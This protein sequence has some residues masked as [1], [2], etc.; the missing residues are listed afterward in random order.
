MNFAADIYAQYDCFLRDYPLQQATLQEDQ[1]WAWVDSG[2]GENPLVLLPGLMGEAETSFLYVEA[3]AAHMRVISVSYP[4]SVGKVDELCDGLNALLDHLRIPQATILG[5]SASG[6]VAQAFLRRFPARTRGLILTHT[7]LPDPQR[8]RTA[9][10][11]QRLL[12]AVPFGLA[13]GLMQLSVFAFFPRPTRAHAFWRGHFRG[14][15]R[16]LDKT[17]LLNRFAVMEDF[18]N[19]FRFQPGRNPAV[20]EI[21]GWLGAQPGRVLLMEMQRDSMTT[22]AE[23][24]ALRALYPGARVQ[25]FPDAAHLD[26][27]EQPGEQIRVILDFMLSRI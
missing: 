21:D 16:R 9:Q 22:P 26:S 20:S 8:A 17:A 24:A 10:S 19:H 18:H 27:V 6:F 5:G 7:G 13:R 25:R 2:A 23:Q 4:P 1:A 14:V 12:R 11:I 15:L 3:L